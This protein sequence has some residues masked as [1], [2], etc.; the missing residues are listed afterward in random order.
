MNTI[1][2]VAEFHRAAD[3]PINESPSIDDE[4]VNELRVKLLVEETEELRLALEARDPVEVLDAL[5]DL[6]YVLD[7]AILSLGYR[8]IFNWAFDEVHESNMAK[9]GP[10]GKFMKREDGKVIKPEGWKPPNLRK[11]VYGNDR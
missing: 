9:A 5:V 1:P 8:N 11:F 7:G 4:K 6:Q 3:Q 10:D 2:Y